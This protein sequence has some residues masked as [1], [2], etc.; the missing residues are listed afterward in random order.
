MAE[1][2]EDLARF[3]REQRPQLVG[4]LGLYCGDAWVAEE[5]ANEALARVCRDWAKVRSMERPGAWAHRV[6]MNLA[7]SWFRRR[8]AERRARHRLESKHQTAEHLVELDRADA[9]AVRQ[10]VARLPRRRREVLVY[11]FFLSY[12]VAETAAAMGVSESAVKSLAHRAVGDL[13]EVLDVDVAFAGEAG[14]DS[15]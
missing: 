2:P 8:G 5:L 13:R 14:D 4:S 1:V 3:C 10:A 9:L 15:R 11:R 12:S 7:N 6:G